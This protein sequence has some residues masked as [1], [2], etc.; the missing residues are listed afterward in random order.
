MS[1]VPLYL[2]DTLERRGACEGARNMQLV[3]G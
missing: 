3:S 2:W 1:E